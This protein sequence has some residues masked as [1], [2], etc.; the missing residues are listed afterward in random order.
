MCMERHALFSDKMNLSGALLT[1]AETHIYTTMW[2]P[3]HF[4]VGIGVLMP[5]HCVYGSPLS[6]ESRK[7]YF[8]FG[9]HTGSYSLVCC[10]CCLLRFGAELGYS[11]C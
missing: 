6:E 10:I 5:R 11:H 8:L 1:D 4:R 7:D 3:P 9:P 2:P